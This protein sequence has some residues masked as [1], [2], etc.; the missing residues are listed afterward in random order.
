MNETILP[1]S[2]SCKKIKSKIKTKVCV[3]VARVAGGEEMNIHVVMQCVHAY[4]LTR[5]QNRA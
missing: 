2:L 5:Q 1:Q 4:H 3:C